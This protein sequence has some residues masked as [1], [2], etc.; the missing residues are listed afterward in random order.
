MSRE[1]IFLTCAQ[2]PSFISTPHP[3]TRSFWRKYK[4]YWWDNTEHQHNGLFDLLVIYKKN[5]FLKIS[6]RQGQTSLGTQEAH[7]NKMQAN[8]ENQKKI[9]YSSQSQ[10]SFQKTY[11]HFASILVNWKT[12]PTENNNNKTLDKIL[13]LSTVSTTQ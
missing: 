7:Q 5:R 1:C 8:Q 12:D 3:W 2:Y 10:T 4:W 13:K 6:S 11:L 9:L